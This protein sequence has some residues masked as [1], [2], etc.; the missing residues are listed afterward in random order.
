MKK[1][2]HATAARRSV[3]KRA[4]LLMVAF[5]LLGGVAW[6]EGV[7]WMID[8]VNQAAHLKINHVSF[9]L[10]LGLDLQGGTRLEYS[11]DLANI[12]EQDRPAAMDGV[13]DVI[14]RRVNALGVSEPVVQTT[15]AGNDWRLSVELAGIRDVNEAIKVI[16][17]TPTLDFREEN[18]D[19][20]RDLTDAERKQIADKN[21]ELKKKADAALARIKKGEAKIEDVAK[22]ESEDAASKDNGGDLGFALANQTWIGVVDQ[23]RG[24]K[25]GDVA[26]NVIDDGERL[27]IAQ[28]LETKDVGTEIMASHL[29]IQWAGSRESSSTTTKEEAL[30]RIT[31][32]RSKITSQNFDATVATVSD[33]P[34][35]ENTKGDLGWFTNV[36]VPTL[37]HMVKPFEEAA[38]ALKTGEISGVVETDFGYHIIKK[39][40][41]RTLVDP[42][43]R[44]VVYNKATP[45][46]VLNNEP[47]KRTELTGKQLQRAQLDFDQRTGQ[48]QVSLQ[49]DSEGSKLFGELTKRNI[50]KSI[51]IFL[52]NEP[53]S[54]PVVNQEITGGQAVISGSFTIAEAKLLA[55]R[56][57]AGALPVPINLIAQQTVG[58]SLGAE[59]VAASLRAGLLGFLLVAIFMVLVYRLPGFVSIVALG[60]YAVVVLALFKLIPVTLTLAG[61]AGFI[62]SLGIAVDA[63]VLIY[64]RFKEELREGK[65]INVALEESFRRAWPSIRDG[66]VTVL[67]TCA[68][69]YWFSSSIIRGF[70]LT[71][72][73]GTLISLFT[74]VVSCRTLLRAVAATPLSRVG[75]LFL[76]PR[77]APSNAGSREPKS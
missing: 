4:A 15:K 21:A 47:W 32:I 64:E 20:G 31:D 12:I 69:L 54:I 8:R 77:S 11:A 1:P 40:G 14:E 29:L 52:D 33:E 72:S 59:S 7:N 34:G 23:V 62:L 61:L 68:V 38:Y 36:D 42:R 70:A 48:A 16:G 6:P 25:V 9:P 49:F 73:I 74:A 18:P 43:V 60:F 3:G 65:P 26:P 35:A 30:K 39:T 5:L 37:S 58:P 51:G 76:M 10:A 2:V 19:A 27:V 28:V 71:L 13:R 57:Q 63:N 56:L 17:E 55:Q 75:W 24:V 44:A 53:I 22:A 66:H 41:E 46:D 45:A 67:I 50:N